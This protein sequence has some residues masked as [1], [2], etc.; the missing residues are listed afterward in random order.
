MIS[1]ISWAIGVVVISCFLSMRRARHNH[2]GHA[3]AATMTTE[4]QSA[5]KAFPIIQ[6]HWGV[7]AQVGAVLVALVA[8]SWSILSPRNDIDQIRRDYVPRLE[9]SEAIKR[10]DG[11]V[12][13]TVTRY[14]Y[15]EAIKRMDQRLEDISKKM[16]RLDEMSDKI[17]DLWGKYY[18]APEFMRQTLIPK[19]R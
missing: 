4:D 5:E 11:G 10:L 19:K 9:Y 15:N 6:S 12:S 13:N 2:G 18:D 14:E 16:S 3:G 8:F 7:V 17:A 1:L